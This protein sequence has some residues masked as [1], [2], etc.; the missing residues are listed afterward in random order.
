RAFLGTVGGAS[1]AA[2]VVGGIVTLPAFVGAKSGQAEASD[3][4]PLSGADRRSAAFHVRVD[5]AKQNALLPLQNHASNGDEDLYPNKIGNFSKGLPHDA[6]G[7]VNLAAYGTLLNALHTGRPADF[8]AITMGCPGQ[9]KLVNPQSG[10]AFDL[11][12]TD[13]HQLPFLP[14]PEFAS[15]WQAGEILE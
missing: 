10:L 12:G 15:A 14:A 13:S 5:A 3:I 1:A 2:A 9:R 4:G 7:E 8:E 11:E 6:N